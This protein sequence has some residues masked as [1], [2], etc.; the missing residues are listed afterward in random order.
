MRLTTDEVKDSLVDAIA[1]V[2]L[3]GK[4][5]VL[6]QGG[7]EVAAIIPIEEFERLESLLTKI[8]PSQFTPC[9]DE[10]YA[11]EGGIHCLDIDEFSEDFDDII[12][13]V[14]EDDE[15]FGFLPPPTL[16]GQE[17]DIFMPEA[18]LM[19]IDKFWVPEYLIAAAK[20]EI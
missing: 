11:G 10:Y 3:E 7:T 2:I 13:A 6:L 15:L 20:N 18:I 5:F 14:V 8:K 12:A 4:R 9:E 19:S 1:Q 16:G 17:F